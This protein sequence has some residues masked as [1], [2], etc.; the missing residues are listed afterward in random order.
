MEGKAENAPQP[1]RDEQSEK[2]VVFLHKI[3]AEQVFNS[4][5]NKIN[6]LKSLTFEDFKEWLERVNGILRDKPI[7]DREMDGKNMTISGAL[8]G[9]DAVFP[10]FE[11]KENLLQ[12]V[13]E[14]VQ[15]TDDVKDV[16]LLLSMAV[17]AIHPFS[18]GNG[19]TSRFVFTLFNE[20][21]EG[22][23]EQDER[24]KMLLGEYGRQELN[25]SSAS[26]EHYIDLKILSD[27]GLNTENKTIPRNRT[28]P[29]NLFPFWKREKD[30]SS[31]TE[32]DYKALV[33]LQTN[34]SFNEFIAVYKYLKQKGTLDKY[35]K[36]INQNGELVRTIIN[37]AAL[38]PD[39]TH[40]D[41]EGILSTYWGLKKEKIEKMIDIF[42]N[43]EQYLVPDSEK[44]EG[45]KDKTI[46]MK[47]RFRKEVEATTKS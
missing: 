9:T 41:V 38:M 24:L 33:K 8:I 20:N 36:P 35:T 26:L 39:L 7:A 40:E 11:D 43:P 13:F 46:T 23:P 29:S 34:D 5:E 4:D 22:N 44:T 19:R 32:E 6:F 30:S 12:K 14:T 45:E 25:T 47:E 21:Y 2:L 27:A 31:L 10:K 16:A 1:E 28:V 15:K 42:A 17:V 37:A 3:K 18:D